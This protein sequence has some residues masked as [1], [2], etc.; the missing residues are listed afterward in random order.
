[1]SELLNEIQDK[2]GKPYKDLEFLLNCFRE[3]LEENGEAELAKTIP[4]INDNTPNPSQ[5]SLKEIQVFSIAF[6]LLNMSEIHGAVQNRRK[7]EGEH[8]FENIN[9][10]WANNLTALKG[11]G[12]SQEEIASSLKEVKVEPVLTAHP[13]EAKRETVLEHHKELYRLIVRIDNIAYND[14]EKEESVRELKIL[15]DKLWRT[16]ELYRQKPDVL[17]ELKNVLYYLVNI[18]PETIARTD[19][20]LAMAWKEV[21][22]NEELI[23]DFDKLPI[24]SFGDWV[25]GDR[26]GHPLVTADVTDQTLSAMRLNSFI[27]IRRYL[28]KLDKSLTLD[29]SLDQV[30]GAF[31]LRFNEV[32]ESCGKKGQKEIDKTPTEVYRQF[33]S[34]MLLKLPLDVRRSH[35]T[36]L[37]EE[38]FSYIEDKELLSDL[39]SLQQSLISIGA[40]RLAYSEVHEVLRIVSAFGFHL[41]HVDIRQNSDF[42]DKAISQ[43]MNA[44][45]LK[46]EDYFKW[47]A[48][49]KFQFL[50]NE[51]KS[52][53]PFTHA[54]AQL[55]SNARTVIDCLTVVANHVNK[56]GTK[57]IGSFIVSMT[58]SAND[59]MAVYLLAREVGLTFMTEEGLVCKIPVVP[60]LETIEDLENGPEIMEAFLSHPITKRSLEY[61]RA[62]TKNSELTQQIMVGYSDSNKDGGIMASQWGLYKAQTKLSAICRKF[63]VN[64]RF[65]HGKG[66][67]ISRGAGP[68]HWFIKGLPPHSVNGNMRLTEQGETINQKY[69]NQFQATYNMEI[70]LAGTSA[71]LLTDN[72][73]E[74]D[75]K[76]PYTDIIQKLATWSEEFYTQMIH[77]PHFLKFFTEATPIDVLEHSKIG[78]RPARRTGTRSLD[79]LRAIPWVFS[80]SQSRFNITS[81]F[82]IGSTLEKLMAEAPEDFEKLK[83]AIQV[84][85]FV[86]YV[87]TNVDTALATTD[88]EIMK[89]YASMVTDEEAKERMLDVYLSEL[90]RTKEALGKL[91]LRSS[92]ERRKNH[93]YSTKLRSNAMNMLHERQVELIKKWRKQKADDAPEQDETLLTILMTINAIASAMRSTG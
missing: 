34:L 52:N 8:K 27:V 13:T 55:E 57:G 83:E 10:L 14:S 4:F 69:A 82:G 84:D 41:A 60:L 92:E 2:L 67:S 25:G 75:Y 43:L 47:S 88:E 68:T 90:K 63:G 87:F 76:Y 17:S 33:I 9:G 28:L 39:K 73:I 31:R 65:F 35:A 53:R 48:D 7:I 59:L 80:W 64:S 18:F 66:G 46:G 15:L 62:N 21:G 58:R 16:G 32:L 49:E 23:Q 40:K 6:Q 70:L 81:W 36:E 24:I 86:R 11:L 74:E 54:E 51:L 38:S 22:F 37:K 79:D 19:R 71:K 56:Y 85:P 26:D 45:G 20:R 44:A 5:L 78:S 93:T 12:Y 91:I 29:K 50:D 1:M 61:Q 72:K 3:V 77:E 30:D 42:H 89:M